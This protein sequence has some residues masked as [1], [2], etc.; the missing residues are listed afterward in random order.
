[1][2]CSH[3]YLSVDPKKK[4]A[5][6]TNRLSCYAHNFH[7][8]YKIL[9]EMYWSRQYLSID[10]KKYAAPSLTPITLKSVYRRLGGAF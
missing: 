2:Y 4:F 6:P 8:R 1:M 3:Q 10:S 5:T 7:A 9:T